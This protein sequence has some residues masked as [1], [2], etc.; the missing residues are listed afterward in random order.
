MRFASG[1]IGLFTSLARFGTGLSFAVLIVSVL[2]Q[3]TGRLIGDSPVWTEELSRFALLY[4]V[5][6]GVGLS[7]RS[8]DL[9]NVDVISES[10]PGR[11]PWLLRLLS[12]LITVG[13]ALYVLPQAWR[14][15][16]IGGMQTSPALYVRM[17]LIHL[18]MFLLLLILALF[19]GL[20]VIGML[21]G[22]VDG[23]PHRPEEE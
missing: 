14:Y 1:L 8:G 5:A 2:V 20:R 19:G 7:L 6:F 21:S 10:L 11:V 17:D 16:V 9:V 12:A 13:M 4:L 22:T 3:V 18:T 23:R 15:T